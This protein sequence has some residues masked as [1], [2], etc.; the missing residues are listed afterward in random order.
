[1][2]ASTR[3]DK[4]SGEAPRF[5]LYPDG[6]IIANIAHTPSP[7]TPNPHTHTRGGEA[8]GAQPH[9]GGRGDIPNSIVYHP[10]YN[11]NVWIALKDKAGPMREVIKRMMVIGLTPPLPPP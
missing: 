7:H 1:M 4:R 3:S 2:K 11:E 6:N 9:G 8:V 5:I 10:R